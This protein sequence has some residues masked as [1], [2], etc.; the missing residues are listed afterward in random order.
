MPQTRSCRRAWAA[1]LVQRAWRRSRAANLHDVDP[2]S[3]TPIAQLPLHRVWCPAPDA[4]GRQRAYDAVAWLEW[5]ARSH[6]HPSLSVTCPRRMP[7]SC[8]AAVIAALRYRRTSEAS[9]AL[10]T[11]L[12][13]RSAR[14]IRS[15]WSRSLYR[16]NRSPFAPQRVNTML[17]SLGMHFAQFSHT[18]NTS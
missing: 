9:K 5:F 3:L 15:S 10:A 11:W 4:D 1:T 2:I 14:D 7:A 8:A 18:F 16:S 17:I 12:H 6:R 13:H